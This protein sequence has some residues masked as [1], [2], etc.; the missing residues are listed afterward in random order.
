M[1]HPR[2]MVVFL[3]L[4]LTLLQVLHFL[5]LLVPLLCAVV[6]EACLRVKTAESCGEQRREEEDRSMVAPLFVEFVVVLV[7]FLVAD[8]NGISGMRG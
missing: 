7:H 3:L 4:S 2:M 5:F 1:S 8:M 6:L